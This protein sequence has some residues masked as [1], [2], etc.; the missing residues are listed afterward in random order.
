[1]EKYCI[2]SDETIVVTNG[3]VLR[4]YVFRFTVWE[5]CDVLHISVS[6]V[7]LSSGKTVW[8]FAGVDTFSN[9][10]A[11]TAAG[12]SHHMPSSLIFNTLSSPGPSLSP[13]FYFLFGISYPACSFPVFPLGPSLSP[14][15][16]RSL[17]SQ[18]TLLYCRTYI[19][20][21]LLDG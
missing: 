18:Q 12:Q 4:T 13:A 8:K 15:P 6:R 14:R 5:I 21:P 20:S 1:M 16:T 3:P 2:T 7:E 11:A 17:F 9:I 10:V 19:T